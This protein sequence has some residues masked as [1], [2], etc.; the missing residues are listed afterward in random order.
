MNILLG[1]T[2]DNGGGS[3]FLADAI[4]KYTEHN[5]RACVAIRAT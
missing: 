4:N 1:G 5:A 2:S 3:W